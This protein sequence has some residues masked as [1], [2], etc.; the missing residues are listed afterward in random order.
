M[1]Q[2]PIFYDIAHKVSALVSLTY[3]GSLYGIQVRATIANQVRN[4]PKEVAFHYPSIPSQWMI[5]CVF[6]FSDWTAI[7]DDSNGIRAY[8][9]KWI[10]VLLWLTDRPHPIHTLCQSSASCRWWYLFATPIIINIVQTRLIQIRFVPRPPHPLSDRNSEILAVRC[11]TLPLQR[12][13]GAPAD[14]R[15]YACH[16]RGNCWDEE[17]SV[18]SGKDNS[19]AGKYLALLPNLL[20]NNF[21]H[22]VQPKPPFFL[23]TPQLKI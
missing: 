9:A 23:S 8:W 2:V 10:W 12:C 5:F 19:C 13:T 16:V 17:T 21:S 14:N 7:M 20:P 15:H 6:W 3:A 22:S 4:G 11:R 1:P 18:A